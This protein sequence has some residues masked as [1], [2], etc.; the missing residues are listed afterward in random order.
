MTPSLFTPPVADATFGVELKARSCPGSF[1]ATRA[2]AI[3]VAMAFEKGKDVRVQGSV[4]VRGC[5]TR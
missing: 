4:R 5:L 3:A 1:I 2:R